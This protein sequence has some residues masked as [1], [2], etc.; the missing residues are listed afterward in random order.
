M[1]N[2]TIRNLDDAVMA[3]IRRR[4]VRN[5]HSI[6]EEARQILT[7]AVGS[8]PVPEKALGTAIYKLFKPFGGVDLELPPRDMMREPPTFD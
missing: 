4:A 1:A 3:R 5:D 2:L 7:A 6:V 8:P